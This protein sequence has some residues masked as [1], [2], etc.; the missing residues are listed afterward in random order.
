MGRNF[1]TAQLDGHFKYPGSDHE[2]F[3]G[4]FSKCQLKGKL[5]TL[6]REMKEVFTQIVMHK[7]LT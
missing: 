1:E 7:G 6:N 3:S 4:K 5:Y 2:F